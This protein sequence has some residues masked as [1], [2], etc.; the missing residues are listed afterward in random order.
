MFWED[1]LV[2]R[3]LGDAEIRAATSRFFSVPAGAVLLVEDVM[4]LGDSIDEQ[5]HVVCERHPVKGQFLTQLCFYL[6]TRTLE[7]FV[8]RLSRESLINRLCELLGCRALVSVES[9]DPYSFLLATGSG[10]LE[11]V[12]V[13]SDRLDHNEEYVISDSSRTS[14]P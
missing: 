11:P 7:E 4:S 13:D 2:D 10:R 3:Q 12:S 8:Q 14:A 9:G 6:R 1:I 5:F